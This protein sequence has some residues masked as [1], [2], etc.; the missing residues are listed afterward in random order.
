VS[1]LVAPA[2]A[3]VGLSDALWVRLCSQRVAHLE[4]EAEI[5]RRL[6]GFCWPGPPRERL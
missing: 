2:G 6:G 5:A 1:V 4:A 3:D